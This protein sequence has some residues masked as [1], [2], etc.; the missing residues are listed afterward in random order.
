MCQANPNK[1]SKE[2]T[3]ILCF[4]ML[5]QRI[6]SSRHTKK[7][8]LFGTRHATSIITKHKVKTTPSMTC[9]GLSHNQS[10]LLLHF[11]QEL[12]TPFQTPSKLICKKTQ[13]EWGSKLTLFKQTKQPKQKQT[14]TT[15]LQ[16][17]H[18]NAWNNKNEVS[19][20]TWAFYWWRR[21]CLG[22]PQALTLVP[23]GYFL[24]WN[25]GGIPKLDIFSILH[26]IASFF[27][28]TWNFFLHTKLHTIF[29]SNISLFKRY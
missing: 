7:S 5:K 29:I 15:K 1:A 24:G 8:Q 22:H 16:K 19:R 2:N 10:K 14:K 27:L 11:K 18:D 28:Y 6:I 3:T 23:L 4:C 12:T 25:R 21:G 9:W 26:L 13:W 20:K 17:Q